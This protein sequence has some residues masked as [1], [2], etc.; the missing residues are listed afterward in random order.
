[1]RRGRGYEIL[2]AGAVT[3]VA[4]HALASERPA[5]NLGVKAPSAALCPNESE[6]AAAVE[7]RLLPSSVVDPA[8]RFEVT[9]DAIPSGMS[10]RLVV[11]DGTG[12]AAERIV[13]AENCADVFD[14]VAFIVAMT[15]DPKTT[16]T[17]AVTGAAPISPEP[18]PAAATAPTTPP[19]APP[20]PIAS[21]AFPTAR[22]RSDQTSGAP[23]KPE[24]SL[25]VELGALVEGTT[26]VAPG[27]TPGGRLFGGLR[28]PSVGI[29]YPSFRLSVARSV[30]R[31]AAVDDERGGYLTVTAGR[32]ET[33]A[34]SG[35]GSRR[36]VVDLCPA[37]DLGV[38][39]GEGYGVTPSN[40]PTRTW[41]ALDLLGRLGL[42]A[43]DWALIQAEAGMVIPV[44]RDTFVLQGPDAE[45]FETPAL[46]LVFGGGMAVRLP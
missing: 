42:L 17:P 31:D 14:T 2:G 38:R 35:F 7:R 46:A 1:M 4:S 15:I 28:L 25:S 32:L 18:A 22:P 39:E 19:I 24:R 23:P 41:F 5:V 11:R 16:E 26:A 44:T 6:L 13:E 29:V 30:E 43:G 21:I 34:S 20:P 40:T 36:L 8:L 45:V 33:C 37:A 10:A 9:I 27:V 12:A 3:F